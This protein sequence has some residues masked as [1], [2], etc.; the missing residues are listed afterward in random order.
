[1]PS[2]AVNLVPP[3]GLEKPSQI[4]GNIANLRNRGP[5]TGPR[6]SE[7]L[8]DPRLIGLIGAWP[9]LP[10][11][12][13]QQLWAMVSYHADVASQGVGKPQGNYEKIITSRC[14]FDQVAAHV[15]IIHRDCRNETENTP[16]LS[17]DEAP[18]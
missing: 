2:S 10:E 16:P 14:V 7:P 12:I 6:A 15:W 1:M 8:T 3:V 18:H 17:A 9:Q 13:R 11:A 4:A 5:Q